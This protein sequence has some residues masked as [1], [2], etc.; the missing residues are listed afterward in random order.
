VPPNA[1]KRTAIYVRS[2]TN[3]RTTESQ[4]E[5]CRRTAEHLGFDVVH[6]FVDEGISGTIATNSR[7]G[8]L[9]LMASLDSV[10][11]LLVYRLDRL[12]RSAAELSDLLRELTE[13]EVEVWSVADLPIP[14]R[15][16]TDQVA[17][18]AAFAES[19]RSA[20]LQRMDDG[21]R[22]A[23]EKGK[24]LGG[25]VPFGYDLDASG[26]LAPS[27][28]LVAGM[29]EAELARSVFEHLAAGSST[30]KEARRMNELGVFPGRRYANK[31]VRMKRSIW[32]PSRIN[33]MVR[34]PLYK[35]VHCIEKRS[36]TIE[37]RVAPLVSADLWQA[38]QDAIRSNRSCEPGRPSKPHLLRGLMF[39]DDCGLCFAA[40]AV[41][42]SQNNWRGWYYRCA[43]QLGTVE[44]DP[45]LRC[46]AKMVPASSIEKLVWDDCVR[47]VPDAST[48]TGFDER[49]P[50]VEKC[51]QRIGVH[52]T[53]VRPHKVAFVRVDYADG[54]TRTFRFA[55]GTGAAL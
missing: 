6:E 8:A 27:G 5:A 43:G 11:V 53:G 34:N 48:A 40:T 52:T 36:G 9:E 55:R 54:T 46:K 15:I 2:S 19:E 21:V 45:D 49:R 4:L 50:V 32:F 3:V 35:G 24:W 41:S 13:S 14:A 33:A 29:A 51:V 12:S 25:P 7:P 30:V 10:E 20:I 39:C 37:R 26:A 44:P 38:A 17:D 1:E 31:V 42:S 23:A 47:M 18:I 28:R 16:L 22:R